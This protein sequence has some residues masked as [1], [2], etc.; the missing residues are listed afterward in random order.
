MKYQPARPGWL[1][2]DSYRLSFQEAF[3][4]T[5][6]QAMELGLREGAAEAERFAKECGYSEGHAEGVAM[7]LLNA[8]A[9]RFT[10]QVAGFVG[11]ELDK[12]RDSDCFLKVISVLIEHEPI[13]EF[14]SRASKT[15]AGERS[16]QRSGY[17]R[18]HELREELE[19]RRKQ[20]TADT[21]E[22]L[23]KLYRPVR[24]GWD[25]GISEGHREGALTA[26]GHLIAEKFG[27]ETAKAAS[28]VIEEHFDYLKI[29]ALAGLVVE[30]NAAAGIP[31][32][33]DAIAEMDSAELEPP[34]FPPR[35]SMEPA[36]EENP[37]EWPWPPRAGENGESK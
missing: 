24:R 27:F 23:Q 17:L 21:I 28:P 4:D 16:Q 3:R 12:I 33:T 14:R 35:I 7:V 10:P 5:V 11:A 29:G 2:P 20:Y 13:H 32:W 34:P 8:I 18:E 26:L 36:S 15:I 6:E 22:S 31:Y 19:N 1:R 25:A 30:I 9:S 37:V